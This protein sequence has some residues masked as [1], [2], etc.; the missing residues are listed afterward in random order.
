MLYRRIRKDSMIP[1]HLIRI[2]PCHLLHWLWALTPA[3]YKSYSFIFKDLNIRLHLPCATTG[4][5]QYHPKQL[6][7]SSPTNSSKTT[8]SDSPQ[9]SQEPMGSQTIA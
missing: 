2:L 8:P 6:F 1:M 7:P 3:S 9:E 4:S 5:S